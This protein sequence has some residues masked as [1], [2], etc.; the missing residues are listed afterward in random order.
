MAAA[1]QQAGVWNGIQLDINRPWTRFDKAVFE[2]DKLVPEPAV[3]GIAVGDYRLFRPYKRDFFY[4]TV[5]A[6]PVS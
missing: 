4:L 2:N 5:G 6:P 3:D 1:M